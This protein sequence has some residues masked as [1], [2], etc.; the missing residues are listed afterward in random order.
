MINTLLVLAIDG[1][2]I[3]GAFLLIWDSINLVRN[4]SSVSNETLNDTEHSRFDMENETVT[5]DALPKE[6][7]EKIENSVGVVTSGILTVIAVFLEFIVSHEIQIK[8]VHR[9]ICSFLAGVFIAIVILIIKKLISF[10]IIKTINTYAKKNGLV[11]K[12]PNEIRIP[13]K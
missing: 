7:A 2:T 9:I 8:I 13:C 6:E 1:L 4:H 11:R 3:S 10:V 5:Y 12:L